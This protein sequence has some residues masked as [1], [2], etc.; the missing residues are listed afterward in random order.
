MG[1]IPESINAPVYLSGGKRGHTRLYYPCLLDDN[2]K[3]MISSIS[4]EMKKARL[5]A[6][7]EFLW[8][9]NHQK[10]HDQS[11]SDNNSRIFWIYCHTSAIDEAIFELRRAAKVSWLSFIQ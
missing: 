2:Y 9:P 4:N 11:F 5:I 6:P 8:S 1:I 3:T 10:F 7:I